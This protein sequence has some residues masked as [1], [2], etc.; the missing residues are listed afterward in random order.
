MLLQITVTSKCI[1]FREKEC[2]HPLTIFRKKIVK[3]CI[4]FWKNWNNT[5]YFSLTWP[6]AAS[7]IQLA[8]GEFS[9]KL[10]LQDDVKKYPGKGM[11]FSIS[12][13]SLSGLKPPDQKCKKQTICLTPSSPLLL[14]IFKLFLTAAP[15]NIKSVSWTAL[16]HCARQTLITHLIRAVPSV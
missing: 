10:N 14:I 16:L 3:I 8:T 2:E 13:S 12:F 7:L 5:P 11:E 1:T 6:G 4:L 9:L 15:S